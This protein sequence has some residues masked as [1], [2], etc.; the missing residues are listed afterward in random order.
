MR[1]YQLTTSSPRLFPLKKGEVDQLRSLT[2]GFTATLIVSNP[3]ATFLLFPSDHVLHTAECFH[4]NRITFF[5]TATASLSSPSPD[6]LT[7][8]K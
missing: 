3:S 4:R 7:E 8:N 5:P 6:W 1:F 2:R